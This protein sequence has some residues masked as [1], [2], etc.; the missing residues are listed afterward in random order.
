MTDGSS[1]LILGGTGFV[2]RHITEAALAAGHRPTLF[3]RGR[4]N[5]E[6]FLGVERLVGDRYADDVDALR[7]GA[8]DAVIDVNGY[9]PSHVES[10]LTAL[11]G[12]VG[13]YTFISTVSVYAPTRVPTDETAALDLALRDPV[14]DI[15]TNYGPLKVRCEEAVRAVFDDRATIIRPGIV[16]GPHDPT[17][18]FTHWVR[19]A[20]SGEELVATRPEQPVQVIHARDQADFVVAATV[21]Q[22]G[23]TFNT[24]GPTEPTTMADLLEACAA[25]AGTSPAVRWASEDEV[26]TEGLELPLY[27]PS[28]MAADGLFSASCAAAVNAGLTNRPLVD[29]AADTLAWTRS[30]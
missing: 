23:G 15:G 14:D 8:W 3:N 9:H 4:T 26:E 30:R 22:I 17:E 29:T 25:A 10:V 27:L 24:T 18:R 19:A 7:S 11:D 1:L 21:G 12:R 2:G 5:D 6:L 20:A 13:H 16:A 28:A